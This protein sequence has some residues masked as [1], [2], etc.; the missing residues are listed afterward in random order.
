[1]GCASSNAVESKLGSPPTNASATNSLVK[2]E[3]TDSKKPDS[4]VID[5]ENR[6]NLVFR[7]KRQNVFNAGYDLDTPSSVFTA[8]SIPKTPGQTAIISTYFSLTFSIIIYFGFP[9]RA[10]VD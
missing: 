9:Y 1:M 5:K 10:S 8:K 6:I 7:V 3:S 4:E 2:K